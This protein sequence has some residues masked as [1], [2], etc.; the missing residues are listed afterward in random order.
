MKITTMNQLK[1]LIREQVRSTLL[2]ES[3]RCRIGVVG[4]D[5]K[6]YSIYSHGDGYPESPGVGSILKRHYKDPKKIKQLINLGD[7]SSLRKDIGEKHNFNKDFEIAE[8][9]GWTTAYGRD[10]GEKNVKAKKSTGESRFFTLTNRT[11][12]EFAYLYKPKERKWYYA[13]IK[14]KETGF[15]PLV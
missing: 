8:K 10:R 13:D 15:K 6:I 1:R 9:N 12:G 11:G 14:K 2:T 7:V 4:N 3:T 5:G